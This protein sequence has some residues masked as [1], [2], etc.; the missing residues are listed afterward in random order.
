MNCTFFR[1]RKIS[2][3][4]P[5]VFALKVAE[6]SFK[7]LFTTFFAIFLFK[8]FFCNFA[9]FRAGAKGKSW[10]LASVITTQKELLA[11]T[12]S[13]SRAMLAANL[14]PD[15]QPCHTDQGVEA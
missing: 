10:D 13:N 5:N 11:I 15:I 1:D 8:T 4:L 12:E 6:L 9:T 2:F 3:F 7:R 14:A